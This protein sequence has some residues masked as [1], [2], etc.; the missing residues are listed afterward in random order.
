MSKYEAPGPSYFWQIAH[1]LPTLSAEIACR[2]G[3]RADGLPPPP[4]RPPHPLPS[5]LQTHQRSSGKCPSP[6]PSFQCE[7]ARKGR[8]H[9]PANPALSLPLH[10]PVLSVSSRFSAFLS[11]SIC[12]FLFI[13]PLSSSFPLPLLSP[14]SPL[15][16]LS[17]SHLP[18][19][20][21]LPLT[22]LSPSLWK[23]TYA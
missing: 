6:V 11:I 5:L 19:S 9:I 16:S 7:G 14:P 4:P 3:S 15:T 13:F 12:L 1:S 20:L 21:P 10:S 22:S 17:P 8:I 18:V 23:Y 2:R